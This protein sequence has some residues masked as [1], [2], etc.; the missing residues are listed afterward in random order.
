M[1]QRFAESEVFLTTPIIHNC[2]NVVNKKI[3][4][5]DKLYISTISVY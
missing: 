5:V 3:K 4:I 2:I 1:I